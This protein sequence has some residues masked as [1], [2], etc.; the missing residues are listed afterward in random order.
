[1]EVNI[2]EAKTNFSKLIQALEDKVEDEVIISRKGKPI[3]KIVLIN[4]NISK[5]IGIAKNEMKGFDLSLE[6][7]DSIPV[8]GFDGE[9]LW[10]YY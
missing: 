2:Y 3:A 4:K 10:N 8:D 1:M 9:D 6:A 7:F 5:R